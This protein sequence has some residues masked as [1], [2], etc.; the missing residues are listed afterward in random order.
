[1]SLYRIVKL[2]FVNILIW[3][4]QT[5]NSLGTFEIFTSIRGWIDEVTNITNSDQQ[6]Y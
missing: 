2:C 5:I 3:T 6:Y 4:V 1:M